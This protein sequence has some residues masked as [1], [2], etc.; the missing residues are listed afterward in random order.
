MWLRLVPVVGA[1][2]LTIGCSSSN[3]TDDAGDGD[4]A[5]D[6]PPVDTDG[7][8]LTDAEEAE[9]GSDPELADTDG[10]GLSDADERDNGTDPTKEDTDG[11][12][13]NDADE[14]AEGKDPL[15]SASMIYQCG[16][17]YN[18]GKAD[19]DAADMSQVVSQG[20]TIG[21]FKAEDQCGEQVNLHDFGG[22]RK[23]TLVDVSADWCGPCNSLAA[24][25]E[26]DSD[27]FEGSYPGVRD[28]IDNGDLYW[29]TI[30]DGSA[31]EVNNWRNKYPHS[32]I[33]V[34]HDKKGRMA[35]HIGLNYFP[36]V[37]LLNTKMKIVSYKYDNYGTAI[38][39]AVDKL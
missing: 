23:Y 16:W 27:S 8:G 14:L 4:G 30:I 33:P 13:Y 20:D 7:D 35:D 36:S 37:L 17:P 18:S 10:D 21:N 25:L 34:L 22:Q 6:Q 11:D 31:S 2:A 9:F 24:W 38:K 3:V 26:G 32:E 28:A 1:L 19:L 39:A 12:G 29:I 5:N 15:D